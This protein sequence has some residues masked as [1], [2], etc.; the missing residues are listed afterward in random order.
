MGNDFTR[1]QSLVCHLECSSIDF[2]GLHGREASSAGWVPA[3]LTLPS[4]A[5]RI[6]IVVQPSFL[7][8][9]GPESGDTS[10]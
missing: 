7:V 2:K 6:D 3:T 8:M 1:V 10:A 4:A 5:R 9:N